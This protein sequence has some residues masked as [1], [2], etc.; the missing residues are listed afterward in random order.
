MDV[1]ILFHGT[2]ILSHIFKQMVCIIILYFVKVQQI[3]V[4]GVEVQNVILL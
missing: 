4:R 1:G 3:Q 2:T